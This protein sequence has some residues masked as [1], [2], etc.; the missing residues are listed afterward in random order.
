MV[1]P[2]IPPCARWLALTGVA[3]LA[4]AAD[5]Y[6]DTFEI[7]PPL[8]TRDAVVWAEQ[9]HQE[10]L[11]ARPAADAPRV[12]VLHVPIGDDR[13]RILWTT[14]TRD[15]ADV[16][17]LVVPANDKIED[18]EE[19]LVRVRADG[20][21]EPISL[22]VKAPFSSIAL[23][24]DGKRVVLHFAGGAGTD[25]LQNANQVA[26]VDLSDDSARD[27]TLNGFGG[28]LSAVQFPAADGRPVAVGGS[29]REIIA[30][31]AE[32]EIVLVDAADPD[33]DQVAVRFFPDVAFSPQAT[34]LRPGNERFDAPVLFLRAG[35]GTDVAMLTLVDR[36]DPASSAS[37]FSAQ[38][39]LVPV[40]LGAADFAL[41]DSESVP[42]LVTVYGSAL[43]FIDIRTQQGFAVA[44]EGDASRLLLRTEQGAAGPRPQLVAWAPGGRILH[45][46]DLDGIE[47]ALGRRPERLTIEAGI[48]QLVQLD[49]DRVLIGSGTSLYVVDFPRSQ[50]TPLTS[51]VPYDPASS[52]L[53]G[54]RLLLGT[55][56]QSWVSTV[57]LLTLDP[58]S[59]ALDHPIAAF[60]HLPG[61]GRLA[62]VH[63][64]PMGLLTITDAT[65]PSRAQS[66]SVWGLFHDDLLER[67]P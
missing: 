47:D 39:S 17:A 25:V 60:F 50:V 11:L 42:Y 40:G 20:E 62:I 8:G 28:R 41:H 24:P 57:D 34:L 9:A 59:M 33:L 7:G 3:A 64:D 63:D 56:G 27:L 2:K 43:S 23:G 31:L 37:G 38:V 16:L 58:E 36:P 10:L 32:G 30:F 65:A 35:T 22:P 19:R 6:D 14:A 18:V 45:R 53:Q 51:V 44:L 13:S 46:L 61:P 5:P 67:R 66:V 12:D 55:P 26:L 15:G 21:G 52:A 54:D 48:E 4:C 49:N 1:T 29:M